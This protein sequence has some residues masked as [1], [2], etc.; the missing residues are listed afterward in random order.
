MVVKTLQIKLMYRNKLNEQ[1]VLKEHS[2]SLLMNILRS[3]NWGIFHH[4]IHEFMNICVLNQE[5]WFLSL[6]LQNPLNI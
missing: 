3:K 4:F 1:S 5:R 2:N 6:Y